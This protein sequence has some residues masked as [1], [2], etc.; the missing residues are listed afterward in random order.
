MT[1][2]FDEPF[3]E[4]HLKSLH[5]VT[6]TDN[7]KTLVIGNLRNFNYRVIEAIQTYKKNYKLLGGKSKRYIAALDDVLEIFQTVKPGE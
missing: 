3:L 6:A 5:W 1:E 4:R 2:I 7:D